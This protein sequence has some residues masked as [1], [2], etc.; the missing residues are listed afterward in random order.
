MTPVA[1]IAPDEGNTIY[2]WLGEPVAYLEGENIFRFNG[3]YLAWYERGVIWNHEG[4]RVGFIKSTLP[5][6]TK[7]ESSKAHKKYKPVKSLREFAP[8]KPFKTT[9]IP[10]KPLCEFLSMSK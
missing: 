6:S 10:E 7:S 4:S 5:V 2:L 9:S 1:Y 3:K 8:Y